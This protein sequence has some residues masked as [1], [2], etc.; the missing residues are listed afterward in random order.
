MS[1]NYKF[2]LFEELSDQNKSEFYDKFD[3]FCTKED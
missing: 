2:L 1:L 3:C